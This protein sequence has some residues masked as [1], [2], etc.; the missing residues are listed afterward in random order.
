M[1]NNYKI[2]VLKNAAE[3]YCYEEAETRAYQ[4]KYSAIRYTREYYDHREKYDTLYWDHDRRSSAAWEKLRDMCELVGADFETV[5]R[6]CKAIRRNMQ[7]QHHW[8]HEAGFSWLGMA[9]S[10]DSFRTFCAKRPFE[11][12]RY[13]CSW[14]GWTEARS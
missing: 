1:N 9:G 8:D 12:G 4:K 3:N 2:E 11:T 7:Y 14:R 5:L 13:T 10:E 6:V